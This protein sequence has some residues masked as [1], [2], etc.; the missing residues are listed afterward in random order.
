MLMRNERLATLRTDY[1][2]ATHTLII[3]HEGREAARGDLRTKEGRLAIEAF[4]RRF[5][6]NELRGPPKVLQRPEPQ[7]LGRRRRRSCRSSISP[8]S[9]SVEN[10]DGRAGRSAAFSRQSFMCAA[11]R[12]GE[13]FKLIGERLQIGEATAEGGQ[14]HRALRRD[15]GRSGDRHPRP[16]DTE[17][18]AAEFRPHRLRR[19]C[20]SARGRRYREGDRIEKDQRATGRLDL[21]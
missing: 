6:P 21:F 13:E 7:L 15:R 20:R 19:L 9:R 12:P 3:A 14:A 2:E 17:D 8:R 4:F 5:M 16:A 10:V 11:G 1:D 18:A